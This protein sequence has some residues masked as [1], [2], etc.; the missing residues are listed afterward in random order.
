MYLVQLKIPYD[1]RHQHLKL[2]SFADA[3]L[4]M[5]HYAH[6]CIMLYGHG[7]LH[8]TAVAPALAAVMSGNLVHP[9]AALSAM[10]HSTDPVSGLILGLVPVWMYPPM[11]IILS[12]MVT[13]CSATISPRF[14]VRKRDG[15]STHGIICDVNIIQYPCIAYFVFV[16]YPSKDD[17][18]VSPNCCCHM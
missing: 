4:M 2:H 10:Q 5:K 17:H 3:L 13:A 15:M 11:T 1:S 18:T 8:L 9:L 7:I 16:V 12:P 14:H 6:K